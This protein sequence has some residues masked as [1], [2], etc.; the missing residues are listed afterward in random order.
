[1]TTRTSA[2]AIVALATSACSPLYLEARPPVDISGYEGDGTI[3]RLP[4]PI[5]P[6]FKI[7]FPPFLLST[8][9]SAKLTLV[10]LPRPRHHSPYE[11]AL[12]V[13]LTADEAAH[14]PTVPSWLEARAMGSVHFRVTTVSGAVVLNFETSL[15]GQYW[16]RR[17]DEN[18]LFTIL[19]TEGHP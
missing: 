19:R 15:A 12:V 9:Q 11:L 1:M 13:D 6:G 7:D 3:V 4:H 2:L 16:S 8:P 17:I 10:G 5:N 14:W 18:L